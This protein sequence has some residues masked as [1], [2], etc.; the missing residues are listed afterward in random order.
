MG[1]APREGRR[2]PLSALRRGQAH[3][4]LL[5]LPGQVLMAHLKAVR[6]FSPLFGPQTSP[7]CVCALKSLS[8]KGFLILTE[9]MKNRLLYL[10]LNLQLDITFPQDSSRNEK[11]LLYIYFRLSR[12]KLILRKKVP[13]M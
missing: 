12:K 1:P 8:L 4:Q 9:F 2:R 7:P 5:L 3:P 6:L 13:T 11:G 10:S